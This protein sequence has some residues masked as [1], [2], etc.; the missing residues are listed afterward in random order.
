MT[1]TRNMTSTASTSARRTRRQPQRS[2]VACGAQRDK[3]DLIRLAR[4]EDA[5]GAVRLVVDER[6]RAGGRGAYLCAE[7]ECWAQA[8]EGPA[9]A[10]AL[11][12]SLTGDEREALR[13]FAADHFTEGQAA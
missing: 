9:I 13:A 4:V 3:R 10:R 12:G 2:C 1:T 6:A 11:R 8:V 5:E 7:R